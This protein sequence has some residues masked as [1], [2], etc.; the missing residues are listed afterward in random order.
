MHDRISFHIVTEE[1]KLEKFKTRLA[2]YSDVSIVAVPKC[3]SPS[4]A[5]YKARA[6]EYF[7]I[8][9][10]LTSAD[11]VLHLDE[12]T[13]VDAY[14]LQTCV[15]LIER[16]SVEFAQGYIFYNHHAYW[17]NWFLT[18]GDIIRVTDDLGRYQWQG[19]CLGK[20]LFGVHGSFFLTNGEVEN[21]TTWDTD[22]LV[23]DYWFAKRV[24]VLRD[25]SSWTIS[26]PSLFLLSYSSLS[27]PRL[28]IL[29]LRD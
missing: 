16:S 26:L 24:C 12:E 28:Q 2:G 4:K 25:L 8:S 20:P 29:I 18:F 6:L 9:S 5:K 11:W 19:N 17:G 3:F 13:F 22:N 10:K 23:E 7:R 14:G 27:F 15:D 1:D 21:T